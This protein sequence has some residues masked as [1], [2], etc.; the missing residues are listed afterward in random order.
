MSS[1]IEGR[2]VYNLTEAGRKELESDPEAVRRIWERA[3]SWDDWSR[4]MG[5]EVIAIFGPVGGL[6]KSAFKAA[7]WAAGNSGREE[8][9]RAIILRTSRELDEMQN[10]T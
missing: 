6:V 1:T 8:R 7:K 9:L 3:E 2:R 10:N 5:P 4:N